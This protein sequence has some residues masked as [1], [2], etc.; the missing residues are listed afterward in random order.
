MKSKYFVLF[1]ILGALTTCQPVHAADCGN[2][3]FGWTSAKGQHTAGV[4]A[5]EGVGGKNLRGYQNLASDDGNFRLVKGKK[6]NCGGTAFGLTCRDHPGINMA[7]I[8]RE[9]AVSIYH[10]DQW[11]ALQGDL[12][13]SQYLAYK[14]M[15]MA[16]N[17]GQPETC[18]LIRQFI[19]SHNGHAPDFKDNGAPLTKEEADWINA[20][21]KSDIIPPG[22]QPKYPGDFLPGEHDSTRRQNMVQG[23]MLLGMQR[24]LTVAKSP[25]RRQW[26]YTWGQRIINDE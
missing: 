13:A 10:N 17:L 19:N 8:T 3:L 23:I 15:D 14:L 5:N 25:K 6:V 12:L 7:T 26:L 1:A 11:K 24:Y 4:L 22:Y 18:I 2:A 20:Y 16:V 9:Q 21:T